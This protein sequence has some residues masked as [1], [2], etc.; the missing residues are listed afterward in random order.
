M[1][2]QPTVL[3]S[4]YTRIVIVDDDDLFRESLGLNLAEE[5][6]EV[7][8]FA[9]GETALDYFQAGEIADAVL[10]DWRMP[11]IDGLGV[12]QALREARVEIPVIFLTVLSDET[13][14][15]ARTSSGSFSM[16]MNIVGT[17]C[18]WVTRCAST[19]PTV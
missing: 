19:S 11:G 16:R 18:V 12:L 17:T 2:L 8:D 1:S 4:D 7:V 5:G 9:N 10:L 6:F 15:R 14:W 13:S 3:E